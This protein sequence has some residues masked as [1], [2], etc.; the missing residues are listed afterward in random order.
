MLDNFFRQIFYY[1]FFPEKRFSWLTRER[2]PAF[3]RT[4]SGG[5]G[6]VE[7]LFLG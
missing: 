6:A 5:N 4:D 2:R 3:Q 7:V 1:P